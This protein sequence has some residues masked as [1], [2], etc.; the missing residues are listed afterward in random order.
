LYCAVLEEI[1]NNDG[2]QCQSLAI[3]QLHALSL[4]PKTVQIRDQFF[5]YMDP[6]GVGQGDCNTLCILSVLG[7]RR[8]ALQ[9]LLFFGFCTIVQ[10]WNS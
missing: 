9:T 5:L 3:I 7:E 10:S 4:L 8:I 6:G 1:Y 2:Q